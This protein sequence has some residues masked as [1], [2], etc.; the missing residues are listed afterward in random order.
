[1]T[2]EKRNGTATAILF[3]LTI[4]AS[5]SPGFAYGPGYRPDLFVAACGL[6]PL[7]FL[8]RPARKY[9][10]DT[11]LPALLLLGAIVCIPLLFHFREVRA[12]SLLYSAGCILFF[13]GYTHLALAS[14]IKIHA[15]IRLLR[16]ILI[17][18]LATLIVQQFCVLTGL[19]VFNYGRPYTNPWKLNSLTSEP[20]T[21]TMVVTLLLYFL[22]LFRRREWKHTRNSYY[23]FYDSLRKD[24]AAWLATV[25]VCWSTPNT[26]AIFFFP[27]PFLAFLRKPRKKI[28]D[29][30]AT[31]FIIIAV[32]AGAFILLFTTPPGARAISIGEALITGEPE[33]IYKADPSGAM[34]ILPSVEILQASESNME[35][36]L[37]GHGPDAEKRVY[38]D[39]I[40]A[41]S[42]HPVT[43][44]FYDYGLPAQII[45]WWLVFACCFKKNNLLT[46][47]ALFLGLIYCGGSSDQ[48]FWLLLCLSF[49]YN[50]VIL[51]NCSKADTK[52]RPLLAVQILDDLSG[53][54]VALSSLLPELSRHYSPILILSS[55]KG[56]IEEKTITLKRKDI[57]YQRLPYQFQG[58]GIRGLAAFMSIQVREFVATLRYGNNYGTFY[59]NTI[60]PVGAAFAG[61]LTG[62]YIICHCHENPKRKGIGYKLIWKA[63]L[64]MSEEVVC[65]SEHQKSALGKSDKLRVKGL[66]VESE[67]K[68]KLI[69]AD[70]RGYLRRHVLMLASP[71]EYKG[72]GDYI[73]LSS[74]MPEYHFTLA[75]NGTHEEL[76]R[77]LKKEEV[78]LPPNMEVRYNVADTSELYNKA[79]IVVNL[80][81]PQL[82]EETFGL[83][84][85]EGQHA[86]LP[87]I[88][89]P[90]G[91][92]V[93]RVEEGVEGYHINPHDSQA[94]AAAI[95]HIHSSSAT[96]RTFSEAALTKSQTSES[97][98]E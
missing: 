22:N 76:Q 90:A 48:W 63:M 29:S 9:F 25:W 89:P 69:P 31:F 86:G 49:L 35:A 66:E 42:I 51:R 26:T 28:S 94:I 77:L 67:L 72:I 14:G 78:E 33:Q 84:I 38:S 87:A 27:L 45:I 65:V 71:R 17:L 20:S 95:R 21:S 83:T 46:L 3:L 88:V 19:P 47:P 96:Y 23:T 92:I 7:V 61:R 30:Y 12:G 10:R 8:F 93:E 16:F 52:E 40:E 34:R 43:R 55:G 98:P 74:V 79:S 75:C 60:L 32:I 4:I 57:I 36:L 5:V 13:L 54:A 11:D 18:Y 82:I 80:S 1:M 39:K 62:A 53:S 70:S 81:D 37:V 85:A 59:L 24:W 73:R 58:A 6:S 68:K 50:H 64:A 2:A 15:I 91:G 56:P 97:Y 44:I 41:V